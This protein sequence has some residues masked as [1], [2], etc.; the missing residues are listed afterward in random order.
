MYFLKYQPLKERLRDRSVSDREAL[1]YLV[2]FFGLTALTQVFPLLDGF[3]QW[4]FISGG[5]SVVFAAG[6]VIYAYKSN[7]G[8]EGFDLIQKYLILGWVV[9]VRCLLVSVSLIFVVY[10][11]GEYFGLVEAQTGLFD[12]LLLAIFEICFHQR[13]GRHIRDTRIAHEA[14]DA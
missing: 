11:A 6:G 3:N 8:E 7:G 13:L 12:V 5:L 14:L 2:V 9:A 4:D 1:P 10:S